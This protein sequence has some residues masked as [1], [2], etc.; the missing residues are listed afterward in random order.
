MQNS[1]ERVSKLINGEKTDRAPLYDLLRNDAVISHFSG[2]TLTVENGERVVYKAFDP[3]IDATRPLI[4]TPNKEKTAVR[5]D[6]REER[7]FRWTIWTGPKRYA[8]EKAYAKVLS[9]LH[10]AFE[11]NHDRVHNRTS[12]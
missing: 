11:T 6:G 9:T 3:A 12:R 2:E 1:I 5:D 4:R 8:D 7:Y 10:P